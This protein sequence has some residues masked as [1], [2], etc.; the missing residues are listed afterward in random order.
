MESALALWESRR[1]FRTYDIGLL[2]MKGPSD[3]MNRS[4]G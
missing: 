1:W 2:F 4:P 3:L